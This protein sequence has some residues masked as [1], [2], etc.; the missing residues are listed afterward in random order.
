MFVLHNYF[1]RQMQSVCLLLFARE[2]VPTKS[3]NPASLSSALILL[4]AT[5]PFYCSTSQPSHTAAGSSFA[6]V[7]LG[8]HDTLSNLADEHSMRVHK[9]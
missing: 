6:S 7:C 5:T 2:E 4:E 8:P 3:A 1:S 9:D